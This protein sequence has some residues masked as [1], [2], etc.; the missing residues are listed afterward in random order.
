MSDLT[1]TELGQE[2]EKGQE[3]ERVA[4]HDTFYFRDGNVE[5]LCGE[6]LFRVHSSI[7]SFSSSKLGDLLSESALPNLPTP[8]G[9]PRITLTDSAG[10][11]AILLK[12]IYKPG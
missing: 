9:P 4:R 6:A 2:I 7:V 3:E 5:I 10:D 1:Q 11:F 8:E 12:M